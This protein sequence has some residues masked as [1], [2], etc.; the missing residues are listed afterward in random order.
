[1][2]DSLNN[3]MN[4]T[5]LLSQRLVKPP[6]FCRHREAITFTILL[7]IFPIGVNAEFD[8]GSWN[9]LLKKHVVVLDDGQAT[10]VNYEAMLKDRIT[11]T[12]YLEELA[13]VSRVEFD[14]WSSPEQ[15]A[16][17]INAYNAWTVEL[18]LR[19]YPGLR[20]IRQ[21]G[22]LPFSAWR[23]KIVWLFDEQHSL[24]EVEHGMIRGWGI[25]NEPRI[26]F[27]VNC[28][29]IGCPALRAEAYLGKSLDQQLEE[30]TKLFLSDRTRNYYLDG[31]LYVSNIFNWYEEDFEQ[32]WRG[33]NSVSE[34]LLNYVTELGL[35]SD[36]ILFLEQERIRIRHL[37]YDWHLNKVQ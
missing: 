36:G 32:G 8:H 22:F 6:L 1:M 35:D 18:I 26:H 17:L 28:A 24:D 3:Y 33:I 27:A 19:E 20:S 23:R 13:N 11:I 30:N 5:K 4:M 10:Q 16:F 31:Q 14:A 7:I 21:I 15:L 9:E 12:Q 25:Y 29:A 37:R 2:L 34:F